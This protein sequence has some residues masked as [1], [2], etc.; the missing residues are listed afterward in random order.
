MQHR[1]PTF[2]TSLRTLLVLTSVCIAGAVTGTLKAGEFEDNA[3]RVVS[4]GFYPDKAD[5]SKKPDNGRKECH[6]KTQK[7]FS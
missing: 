5:I 6:D 4:P 1:I 2:S 3:Y 7:V